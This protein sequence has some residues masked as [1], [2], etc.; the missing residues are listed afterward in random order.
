MMKRNVGKLQNDGYKF[1]AQIGNKLSIFDLRYLFAD[2]S[3]TIVD[4]LWKV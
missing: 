2:F 1:G 4:N 3:E